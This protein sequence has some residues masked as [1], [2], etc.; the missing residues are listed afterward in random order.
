MHNDSNEI[1][2]ANFMSGDYYGN[3]L[4]LRLSTDPFKIKV[5]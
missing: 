3:S 2:K 1:E 4:C 5:L